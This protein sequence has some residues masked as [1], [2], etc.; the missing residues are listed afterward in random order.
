M[1]AC[2]RTV[3]WRAAHRHVAIGDAKKTYDAA[4]LLAV[5]GRLHSP[6]EVWIRHNLEQ[7]H[8]R[9]V[10]INEAMYASGQAARAA[11]DILASI[12][13][14]VCPALC[15]CTLCEVTLTITGLTGLLVGDASTHIADRSR[16]TLLLRNVWPCC[17]GATSAVCDRRY[18]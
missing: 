14:K 9:P 15:S 12:F 11:V 18:E 6:P 1:C 7:R 17:I 10:V 2:V 3:F 5:S 4:K 13:L 16:A 8:T